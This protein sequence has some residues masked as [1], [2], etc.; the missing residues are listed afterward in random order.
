ME[1]RKTFKTNK[2]KESDGVWFQIDEQGAKLKIARAN[3]INYKAAQ[4]KKMSRYKHAARAK[5]IPDSAWEEMFN[6][7]IAETI[8][9]DWEGITENGKPLPYSTE[10]AL[11]YLT[12]MKDFRELVMGYADD[13]ANFKDELDEDSEKNSVRP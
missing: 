13:M 2:Q 6:E 3:N 7:L 11:Q 1:L 8:L 9:L 12:D 4:Q 5:T 10:A